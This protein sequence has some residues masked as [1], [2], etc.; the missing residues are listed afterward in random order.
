MAT[1][2]DNKFVITRGVDNNFVFTIKQ[3]GT[4]LPMELKSTDTFTVSLVL[5][6]TGQTGQTDQ[7]VLTKVATKD[8]NLLSGRIHIVV[9]KA[10]TDALVVDKGT[11]V[12]RYY[13]RPSYK[14]V[15]ECVT[16]N[17]G[18]FIAKIPEVYVD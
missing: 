1:C 11:K 4:T 14:L 16:V 5:L 18:N 17:N 7:T 6:G 2:L 10:E 12:D 15:I 3:D 9:T 8:V 13:L